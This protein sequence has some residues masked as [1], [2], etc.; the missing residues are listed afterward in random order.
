M[1]DINQQRDNSSVITLLAL[2]IGAI[3]KK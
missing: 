3:E 1:E 2:T